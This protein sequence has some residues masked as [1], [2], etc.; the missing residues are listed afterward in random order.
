MNQMTFWDVL[1]NYKISIPIIQRDYAQGR[2][3][4]RTNEL[5]K[6]LVEEIIAA[7]ESGRRKDFNF[8]YGTK[9]GGNEFLP[10]DG[11][12]RLTTLYLFTWFIAVMVR[13]LDMLTLLPG[14]TYRVRPSSE[15]FFGSLLPQKEES[16][17]DL[18]MF[19]TDTRKM[20]D[21]PWFKSQWMRDPTVGSV[22]TMIKEI[23]RQLKSRDIEV[24]HTI[25]DTISSSD[26]CPFILTPIFQNKTVEAS[27][28]GSAFSVEVRAARTYINMNARGKVLNDFENLKAL[29]DKAG[30]LG[31][32]FVSNYERTY[33][34]LFYKYAYE[35]NNKKGSEISTIVEAMD[36]KAIC[37]LRNVYYDLMAIAHSLT[38]AT[39]ESEVDFLSAVR[40]K[41]LPD[42]YFEFA[43]FALARESSK[44]VQY[45][46]PR[47]N[48]SDRFDFLQEVWYCYLHNPEKPA[49][50][51]SEWLYL[52]GNLGCSNWSYDFH[53]KPFYML[54]RL[55]AN[56]TLSDFW[57]KA[58]I[59]KLFLALDKKISLSLLKEA[60]LKSKIIMQRGLPY[61]YFKDIETMYNRR[62]AFLL[63]MADYWDGKG[64]FDQLGKYI[65]C[66][67][68][69]NL[70]KGEISKDLDAPDDYNW[71]KL[72]YLS[73][74]EKTDGGVAP[75]LSDSVWNYQVLA[76]EDE[77]PKSIVGLQRIKAIYDESLLLPERN[78]EK[79]LQHQSS[80]YASLPDKWLYYVLNR[81]FNNLFKP[82]VVSGEQYL[83]NNKN[84]FTHV[85]EQDLNTKCQ[86]SYA[87]IR[88]EGTVYLDRISPRRDDVYYTNAKVPKFVIIV[89]IR[90][91]L[92]SYE[93]ANFVGEDVHYY[94][95]S[96][97][98]KDED[99]F[100]YHVEEGAHSVAQNECTAF[101]DRL[102]QVISNF[103]KNNQDLL[104]GL[105]FDHAKQAI[106][107][108][109]LQEYIN[110][111][112][113]EM[114][115]ALPFTLGNCRRSGQRDVNLTLK[116]S[117]DAPDSP[118]EILS[119]SE[120]L[121]VA[122]HL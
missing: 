114:V 36:R 37:F 76:W 97:I 40:E 121:R 25:W 56:Q 94:M 51:V 12:Q 63:W 109:E 47:G 19:C 71:K 75:P 119:H 73:S 41:K 43:E 5:R 70:V 72:Y 108:N 96:G 116:A 20:E 23:R 60:K 98:K 46:N 106:R 58:D 44:L 31:K 79:L 89:E 118:G 90:F 95:Y 91:D 59:G 21:F 4:A 22:I 110:D 99:H 93:Q 9:S 77:V 14:F 33:I 55:A 39:E 15:H 1:Q 2:S 52:L 32:R 103:Q 6:R 67:H 66:A 107:L 74:C 85:L 26:T 112:L 49:Q 64:D 113:D 84:F 50:D 62:M 101:I 10:I 18:Y 28:E 53:L 102:K 30:S 88:N 68:E 87:F 17:E 42:N 8:I 80:L 122:G 24:M 105:M 100:A 82:P 11:Q 3:D 81:D 57:G 117:Y 13:K 54:V 65:S 27:E 61:D 92:G 29:L 83:L 86:A 78:F 48:R 111:Q 7:A 104:Y 115:L 45:C 38:R 34:H 120:C 16:K 35:E 69:Y